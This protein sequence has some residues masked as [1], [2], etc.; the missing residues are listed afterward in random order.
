MQNNIYELIAKLAFELSPD[1]V[2]SIAKEINELNSLREIDSTKS[3]WGKASNSDLY[4]IFVKEIKSNAGKMTSNEIAIALK[5][6]IITASY[7]KE[8]I[9]KQELIW[10]GPND[11]EIRFRNTETSLNYIINKSNNRIF[12]TSYAV[13]MPEAILESLIRAEERNVKIEFLLESS[14]EH[15]GAMQIDS[16]ALLKKYLQNAIFYEWCSENKNNKSSM[17]AKCA[18]ADGIN[19]IV[20]SANLTSKAMNDNIELGIL[21]EGG[22]LPRVIQSIFDDMIENQT[23]IR[24]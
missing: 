8:S 14:V 10:T 24:I 5:T 4:S 15:G 7:V 1:R 16:V 9:G 22:P 3:A 2:S 6:A 17:H 23:I 20:T 13:Y 19:A 18:V 12:I 11:S 21:L